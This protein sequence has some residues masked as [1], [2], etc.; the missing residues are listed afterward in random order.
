MNY[1][2]L[3][4]KYNF[5]MPDYAKDYFDDF[6][7][8]YDRRVP[9]L[10]ESNANMVADA[11][12]LP[13]EARAELIRC[14]KA[15]N[16]N[17]DAHICAAFLAEI[18]VYKRDPWVNYIYTNDLFNVEGLKLEQVGWVMVATML[19]NTLNNKK[20]PIDLNQENLNA[21]LGYTNS[22]FNQ[23]GYWGILEWHWNMLCAGGCMFL[24]GILKFVPNQFGDRFF[25]ITDG[26]QYVTL[27]NNGYYIGKE[28]EFVATEEESVGKTYFYEDE[29][30]YVGNVVAKDSKVEL[31]TTEFDKTVWKDFL[32]AG[33]PTLAIHIPSK[34]E[35]TP[36]NA[37][38]AFIEAVEFYKNFYPDFNAKAIECHSWIFSNE[39][40]KILPESSKIVAMLD[41]VHLLPDFGSFTE[42]IMFIRKGTSMYN[43]IA[44]ERS[45]GTIFHFG[46]MYVP[47]DEIDNFGK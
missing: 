31:T 26:K 27:A 14:A 13:D 33:S 36:E 45:K 4:A 8:G 2:E 12:K 6:I 32:R 1:N 15:I 29:S 30:K 10:S 3:C 18:T 17:D 7:S 47:I 39:L 46:M 21:F 19:A 5:T 11:T 34:I 22:C 25:V 44:E 42:D 43:S 35:Y 40:R 16:D 37:R 38:L 28:N 23:N 24:F 41:S 9:V 20:P